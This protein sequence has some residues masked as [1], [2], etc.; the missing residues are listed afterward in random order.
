M[1]KAQLIHT[2]F[3]AGELSPRLMGRV[4]IEKYRN[5]A[6]LMRNCHPV[7]HGGAKR[8]AGTIYMNDGIDTA[9][10]SRMIPFIVD[11]ATAYVLEF[12]NLKVRFYK[13]NARIGAPYEV[14]TPYTTAQIKQLD[15]AQDGDSLY[16]F[17][18]AL[19]IRIL[20]RFE[21]TNWILINAPFTNEPFDESVG[22]FGSTNLTLSSDTVGTGRTLTASSA[23]FLDADVGQNMTRNAGLLTIT[24][25]TSTTVVTVEVKRVFGGT[26]FAGS[27]C[28]FDV[29][30]QTTCTPSAKDP[31][32]ATITLTLGVAGWHTNPVG[33]YVVING[34]LCKITGYTSTTLVDAKILIALSGTTAAPSLAWSLEPPVWNPRDGFPRTGTFHEQRLIAA[35]S[36]GYPRTIWGSRTA[37]PL[38]F[39]RGTDDAMGFAFAL[40]NDEAARIMWL[41]SSRSLLI[42]TYGGEFTMQGGT[43]KPITPAAVRIRA[44]SGH[45]AAAAVRPVQV[46]REHVFAQRAV[47]KI[48]TMEYRFD[49]DGYAAPDIT[50]LAEHLTK[51]GIDNQGG[52]TE[53]AYQNEP[54]QLLWVLNA[55]RLLSCTIDRDQGVIGWAR[56][57]PSST[58]D[59]IVS[60]CAIPTANGDQVW[61]ATRRVDAGVTKTYIER[62][63]TEATSLASAS[64]GGDVYGTTVDCAVVLDVPPTTTAAVAH[65][66]GRTVA[67]VADG[68][69]MGTQVVTGG[70]I[71][72][73]RTAGKIIAGLPFT[74]RIEMLRPEIGTQM[75]TAQG[76]AM[77]SSKVTLRML[78]TGEGLTVNGQQIPLRKFGSELLDEPSPLFTGDV[79]VSNLGWDKGDSP[80]VIEQTLPLPMHILAVIRELTVSN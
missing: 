58:S 39:T 11:S 24:G 32:G 45:G 5:A 60:I 30:P 79:D 21:D 42:L 37:E 50:V 34:G 38:D 22:R 66:D 2:N 4:D 49:F 29:T 76:Q 72:L 19:P 73:P 71:T 77:R 40:S 3:T 17:H 16:I 52:I 15:Y 36:P 64:G 23:E 31:V 26:V 27:E 6:K 46:G 41:M 14:T 56:H 12:S 63:D 35:G 28:K 54:D 10:D 48:R 59:S 67:V 20:R 78:D 74:P 47:R 55:G 9:T 70:I 44:E 69:Y 33:Y 53:M 18:E 80:L 43:E 13:D 1:P 68:A 7:M 61:L 25:F 65:L 51:S 75:G 62:M 8:R 57:E